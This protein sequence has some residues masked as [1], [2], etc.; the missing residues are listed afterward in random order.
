[1]MR[2]LIPTLLALLL[3]GSACSSQPDELAFNSVF[4]LE[5]E[6][7]AG[8]EPIDP[9]RTDVLSAPLLRS[10]LQDLL[11]EHSDLS[12]RAMR[13]AVDGVQLDRTIEQLRANTDNLTTSLGVVYGPEGAMAFDQLWTSHIEFFNNYANAL[14]RG[15][16]LAADRAITDLGH[17]ESDFSSYIDTATSGNADFHAVLHVLHSHVTQLLEQAEAWTDRDYARAFELSEEAHRHMD[18]IALALAT[19]IS[20]Q[21]PE[22]FPGDPSTEA[23]QTCAARQLQLSVALAARDDLIRIGDRGQDGV[24]EA[25][26]ILAGIIGDLSAEAQIAFDAVEGSALSV[27]R[28][29]ARELL[30]ESADCG[31]YI[32]P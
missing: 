12:I 23:A 31:G 18:V 29:S 13:D 7:S 26:R 30:A 25:E 19:G 22:A 15:D 3:V 8:I 4:S 28:S 6:A 5:R 14:G 17:Y 2:L 32:L 10:L 11:T 24:D 16:R 27:Q 9:N 1:M 20:I 21:Q